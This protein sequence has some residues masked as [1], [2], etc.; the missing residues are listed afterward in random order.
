MILEDCLSNYRQLTKEITR[1]YSKGDIRIQ[2]HLRLSR[3]IS[4]AI[5]FIAERNTIEFYKNYFRLAIKYT[6]FITI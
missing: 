3:K 5:R 6:H 2:N 1:F 4:I